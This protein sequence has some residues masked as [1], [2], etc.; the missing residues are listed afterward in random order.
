MRVH[1]IDGLAGS[2]AAIGQ[3]E[4]IEVSQDLLP[5]H[6]SHDQHILA[7]VQLRHQVAGVVPL[8]VLVLVRIALIR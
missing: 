1:R 8:D 2:V 6:A 3:I 5:P 4:G 7:K